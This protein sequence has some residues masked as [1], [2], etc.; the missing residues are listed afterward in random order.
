MVLVKVQG[1]IFYCFYYLSHCK[2]LHFYR[3][4]NDILWH[5]Y[6]TRIMPYWML[7]C[8]PWLA[9]LLYCGLALFPVQTMVSLTDDSAL[10]LCCCCCPVSCALTGGHS[11]R[12][13]TSGTMHAARPCLCFGFIHDWHLK[14]IW[15][16]EVFL[17]GKLSL[18]NES[19]QTVWA[20]REWWHSIE[21]R[22]TV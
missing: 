2:T 15:T 10:L 4:E 12:R 17:R 14:Q 1:D 16:W 22:M 18:L 13:H 20:A 21:Y 11:V 6:K 5:L 8:N 9:A 3:Y 7:N 19:L